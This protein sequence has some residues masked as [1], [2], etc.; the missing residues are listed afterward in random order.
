MTNH[1]RL[2]KR[3]ETAYQAAG[4]TIEATSQVDQRGPVD[5]RVSRAGQQTAVL[6]TAS[7]VSKPGVVLQTVDQ[8]TG[9]SK[10][11][12][13]VTTSAQQ[14]A[15]LRSLLERPVVTSTAAGA[16]CYFHS[17]PF[18]PDGN[19]RTCSEPCVWVTTTAE[20]PVP[21]EPILSVELLPTSDQKAD[22]RNPPQER[23]TDEDKTQFENDTT[24]TGVTQAERWNGAIE[25]GP[26]YDAWI[27]EHDGRCPP[28][29]RRSL[30]RTPVVPQSPSD[31]E[32][33]TVMLLKSDL[34][35][36]A[37]RLATIERKRTHNPAV[38]AGQP[39]T[40]NSRPFTAVHLLPRTDWN[41]IVDT[42]STH[43]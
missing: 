19:E 38:T 42:A 5:L 39:D 34:T 20:Q 36:K 11:V 29:E 7:N 24:G 37:D 23:D 8:L 32:H 21:V 10:S 40:P 2:L 25:T 18:A 27:T 13:I 31:G 4:Y 41:S 16:E 15:R 3:V 6:V 35:R 9:P 43:P 17:T 33:T 1:H 22:R 28:A 12:H 14:A 26:R 30:L